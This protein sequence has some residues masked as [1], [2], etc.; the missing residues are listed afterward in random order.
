M[1][2]RLKIDLI[3]WSTIPLWSARTVSVWPATSMATSAFSTGML[4]KLRHPRAPVG[5]AAGGSDGRASSTRPRIRSQVVD[6]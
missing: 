1:P 5:S 2:A 4:V 6:P 3:T